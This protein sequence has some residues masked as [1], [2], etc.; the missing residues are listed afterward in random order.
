[1]LELGWEVIGQ[2]QNKVSIYYTMKIIMKPK[3]PKIKGGNSSSGD[4]LPAAAWP[5]ASDE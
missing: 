2:S 4:E 1:M 3:S 5:V